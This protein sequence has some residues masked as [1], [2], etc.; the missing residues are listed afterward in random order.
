MLHGR[1]PLVGRLPYPSNCPEAKCT[2]YSLWLTMTA[3]NLAVVE[4]G[5]GMVEMAGDKEGQAG[6]GT[7]RDSHLNKTKRHRH[8]NNNHLS[9]R[10]EPA[11][12]A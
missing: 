3:K 8:L 5:V 1:L 7:R 4:D 9:S 12:G 11:E 6:D 10:I 2:P